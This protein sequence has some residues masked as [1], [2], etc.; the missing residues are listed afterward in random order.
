MT[1]TDNKPANNSK[2]WLFWLTVGI[3][4]FVFIY[5]IRGILLPFVLGALIAYFLDPAADKLEKY[6]VSR[7]LATAIITLSFFAILTLV[8][9]LIIP[10]VFS[11]LS[12]LLKDFPTYFVD[13]ETKYEEKISG[14]IGTLPADYVESIKTA[15]NNFSGIM[16]K[17]VGD[18]AGGLFQSGMAIINILSLILITPVI[19]FYLLR[20]WD[21]I[22]AQFHSLLPRKH[23]QTIREQMA[24]ID[25]T[26]AGFIR[27]Q[28][29]VCLFLGVFY[30]IGLSVV[31]LKFGILI[32]MLTGILAII[33]YAGLL[34]SMAIGLTVAFFQFGTWEGMLPV[35]IVF[36][37]GQVIEGNFITPKLV[38]E[39]VGLHPAWIIFG[40][41]AGTALFGFVGV[42]IAIPVTAVIGVLIRFTLSRY[43]SSR[44]YNGGMQKISM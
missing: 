23:E 30:A 11:Q 17:F 34:F 12:D 21:V 36:V 22:T 8:S 10:T 4:F 38:G 16:L 27:G 5:L 6:K 14:W 24:I 40:L 41:L 39:K 20:D 25:A 44:Y 15:A 42:L 19:A 31:G 43:L 9:L 32:G 28:I 37:V 33:P 18:M 26:L 35:L 7:S 3:V 2:I 29:N 13:M 1:E